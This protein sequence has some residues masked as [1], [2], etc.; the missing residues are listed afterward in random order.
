M[1]LEHLQR[2]F[3]P[4]FFTTRPV[5]KVIGARLS[6]PY[7]RVQKHHGR[8]EMQSELGKGTLST[9]LPLRRKNAVMV[10]T[11]LV[12]SFELGFNQ[13]AACR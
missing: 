7:G 8:I 1:A 9:R 11:G 2:I 13:E 3:A 4:F 5:G 10:G 6:L 12:R